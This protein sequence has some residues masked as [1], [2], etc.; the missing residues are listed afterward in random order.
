MYYLILNEFIFK[1]INH[2][3]IFKIN[4]ICIFQDILLK[5]FGL[6]HHFSGWAR[7]APGTEKSSSSRT[8]PLQVTSPHNLRPMSCLLCRRIFQTY[9]RL[10]NTDG[11][12][13]YV[14]GGSKSMPRTYIDFLLEFSFKMDKQSERYEYL[15][16]TTVLRQ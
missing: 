15:Q 7:P 12:F 4:C 9:R 8:T 3:S 14:A 6:P 2:N 5:W 16:K 13:P 1:R 10:R 11:G